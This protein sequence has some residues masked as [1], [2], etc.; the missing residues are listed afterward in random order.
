MAAK[1]SCLYVIISIGITLF[2]DVWFIVSYQLYYTISGEGLFIFSNKKCRIYAACGVSQMPELFNIKEGNMTNKIIISSNIIYYMM[3]LLMMKMSEKNEFNSYMLIVIVLLCV[4]ILGSAMPYSL[5]EIGI[6][7]IKK[8]FI[9]FSM[10]LKETMFFMLFF[11]QTER[12][13]VRYLI[14][15][16]LLMDLALTFIIVNKINEHNIEDNLVINKLKEYDSTFLDNYLRD[17]M[18]NVIVISIFMYVHETKIEMIISIA[19]CI[20][21]Y[22]IFYFRI[23]SKTNL[24]E[25]AILSIF[26]IVM[27]FSAFYK[28]NLITWSVYG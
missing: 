23:R 28:L 18:A 13:I 24:K 15:L 6:I 7:K 14:I 11:M 8:Y 25:I 1:E 4:G 19:I 12:S 21:Y 17:I 20:F 3:I 27:I 16:V 2:L 22:I 9:E 26:Q 10:I 5:K